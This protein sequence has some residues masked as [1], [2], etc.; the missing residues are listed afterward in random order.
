MLN[1]VD[2]MYVYGLA[3]YFC[4][5][6]PQAF[7]QLVGRYVRDAVVPGNSEARYALEESGALHWFFGAALAVAGR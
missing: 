1:T 5:A 2:E 7:G 4:S 6:D 3:D